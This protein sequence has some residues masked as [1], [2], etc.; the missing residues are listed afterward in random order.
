MRPGAHALDALRDQDAVVGV[1]L[2]HVGHRAQRHQVEQ[3]VQLRLGLGVEHAAPAQFGAQGQQHIE[4]HA[5]AGQVLAREA[6][7]GL[8]R[9]DDHAR[10]RQ[11]VARQVVVGDDDFDAAPVRLQPRRRCWRCRCRR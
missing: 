5:D 11:R 4:H 2:D 8:V 7:L 6:A 9:V 3:V 1:E 10:R